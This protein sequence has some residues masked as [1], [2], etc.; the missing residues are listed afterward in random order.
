MGTSA[1]V[2][3]WSC[4]ALL[5]GSTPFFAV[6]LQISGGAVKGQVLHVRRKVHDVPLL[7]VT[8]G[9][10]SDGAQ[11]SGHQVVFN[12]ITLGM[13]SVSDSLQQG[14]FMTSNAVVNG[15]EPWRAHVGANSIS[16]SSSYYT[17][18]IIGSNDST[19]ED[20]DREQ[21]YEF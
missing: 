11:F 14:T 15:S 13:H 21:E 18:M 12:E 1:A 16:S 20:S 2:Q 9:T 5:W 4:L 3:S 6:V 8:G 17:P 7:H 10:L 19:D